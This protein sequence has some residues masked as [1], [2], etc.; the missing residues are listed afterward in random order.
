MSLLHL[1]FR[2]GP[3]GPTRLLGSLHRLLWLP[4]LGL[5]LAACAAGG[6]A[7]DSPAL[8]GTTWLWVPL[9]GDLPAPAPASARA[10]HLLLAADALRASGHTGC[11]RMSATFELDGTSLRFAQGATTRMACI[12]G[13][14]REQ[15][16]L[17][18]MTAA[19]NWRIE[20]RVLILTGADGTPVMRLQAAAP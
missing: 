12:E 11:N 6:A 2:T 3:T 10:P 8:R 13:M 20:G 9:T 18:A 1:L 5:S 15:A 7:P 17:N 16:F 19:R 4:M 14:D